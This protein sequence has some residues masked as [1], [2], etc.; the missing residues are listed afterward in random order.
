MTQTAIARAPLMTI[1]DLSTRLGVSTSTLYRWRSEG[2]PMPP[3]IKLGG[4]VRWRPEDVEAWLADQPTEA[5]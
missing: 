5:E 2:T 4:A 1:K 3:A